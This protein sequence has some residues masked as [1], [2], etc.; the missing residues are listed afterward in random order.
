MNDF[1]KEELEYLK[2]LVKDYEGQFL[3]AVTALPE[4]IESMID[5][6]CEHEWIYNQHDQGHCNKC[7][8]NDG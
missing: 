8:K 7:G 4:K 6:Y 2:Q 1:K 3:N 5:N